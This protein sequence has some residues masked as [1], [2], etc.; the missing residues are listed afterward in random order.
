MLRTFFHEI[1]RLFPEERNGRIQDMRDSFLPISESDMRKRGWPELDVLLVSADAYV[2]HPS[3]ACALLGRLLESHGYRVGII[4]QPDWRNKESLLVMGK[5]RLCCMISGG[6]IDSMVAHYTS[7]KKKRS[8]DQY[9]PGGKS[10]LRPDRPTIVYSN[11]ARQAFGDTPLI[12]GGLEA[13]LRRLAHYD[14]WQDLVRKSILQD[15]K[16]DLLVYGM[17]ELQTI[18]ITDRL[19]E[20][21]DISQIRD[22]QGTCFSMSAKEFEAGAAL[23]F[24]PVILPSFEEVSQRDKTSNIPT[25]EGRKAYARAFNIQM[26]HENPFERKCLV[27]ASNGRIIVQN[28]PAR[29]LTE[30]EF[31][32]LYELPFKR[33]WHPVYDKDGGVPA[34]NEVQFS[35]TSNR[36]CYGGCSFCAI[37]NHQGRI[38]QTRSLESLVRE[39]RVLTR[40][41]DFKGYINDLGG[42]TANFQCPACEKQLTKGPC[43]HR[44][45]M[46]PSPCPNV[47][48]S[49]MQYIRKLE[50]LASV[51]GVKK[52]FI[53]SGIRFDYLM[54]CADEKT[55]RLFLEK[56][57]RNH[58][59]GQLKVAPEHICN[60]VLQ[61]MGKSPVEVY[62]SFREAYFDENRRQGKKQFIIPYLIA[63]HPG[64]TL[65][66]AVEL[67]LYMKKQG[68]VPD[69]VQEFYP[70]P[71][72]VSTCMYYTGLDP[73]P[74]ENFRKV[75][76][77]KGRDAN[78]QRA[79]LQFNKRENR[80]LVLEAL[81]KAGRP[82]LA[83][84]LLPR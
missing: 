1:L 45:C 29:P 7:T 52:V 33:M 72:T 46:F 50:A 6:N 81:R 68:F 38:I 34:I 75:F 78:L 31:D 70:T 42:P 12:I 74:G 21:Q 83:K 48:D 71:A 62:D 26:M 57:V 61:C 58:V 20:G 84:V 36:G 30:K 65:E 39:A 73:R 54:L 32:S 67:A 11:L 8:T 55:R 28:P 13:S 56:L 17:G 22:I 10:G 69:Q 51:P 63:A 5:P 25:E 59:S 19:A 9:S 80:T 4:A 40:H 16:A 24:E 3:F 76:I 41:K 23:P 47:R 66:N 79:L 49:H 15:S 37:T 14:Y 53:R 2:D 82:E 64:S 77:P 35:I 60:S 44:Q 18:E 27:Q 43:A